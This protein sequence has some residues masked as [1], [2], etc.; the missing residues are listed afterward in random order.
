MAL[1]QGSHAAYYSFSAIHWQQA[2]H[3]EEVIGYLWSLG[4]VAEV[5]IFAFSKRLFAGWTLRAMFIVAAVGVMARWGMIAATTELFALGCGSASS[6]R[7]VRTSAHCC[8]SIHS[9]NRRKQDCCSAGTLQ[10]TATWW[11]YRPNDSTKW[12]GLRA[13]GCKCILGNGG[14]GY[15]GTVH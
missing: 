9:A 2:G 6:R 5:G 14:D 15:R 4:V 12:L 1:L 3:S 11:L 7:D 8:D 10:C 13:L